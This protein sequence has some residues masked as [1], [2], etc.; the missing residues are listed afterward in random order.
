MKSI[1]SIWKDALGG[2]ATIKTTAGLEIIGSL[3]ALN[4]EMATVAYPYVVVLGADGDTVIVP[5]QFT[6][7]A[8]EVTMDPA[9]FLSVS[10]SS[11][12]SVK[13]YQETIA[14]RKE[15]GTDS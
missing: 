12:I 7:D 13:G 6:S 2:V 1:P 11:E 4:D 3:E 5:F 14:A 10:P 15:D 9:G 8:V